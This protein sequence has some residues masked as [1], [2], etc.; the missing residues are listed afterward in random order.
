MHELSG[1]LLHQFRTDL[2]RAVG[3][4]NVRDDADELKAVAVDQYW[5]SVMWTA[6]EQEIAVPYF[7]V[8]PETTE[9]VSAVMSVCNEYKVPVVVR[10][11]GSGTQGGAVSF[12]PGIVLGMERMNKIID[13]DEKS[14]VLTAEP[15]INGEVLELALNERGLML[16]H[17]PSSFAIASLGGYLAAR[18]SGVMSTKYGKAEDLVLSIEVVLADGTIIETL[19][20]P[21][22]ANGPDLLQLFVGS[23]GTLGVITKIRMQLDPLPETRLFAVYEFPTVEDGIEASR[24]IMTERLRPAVIRLYDAGATK[25]SLQDTGHDLSGVNSII[26]VDG[27]SA[28]AEPTIARIREICEEVGGIARPDSEGEHW[29][30]H[31]YDFYR[32]PLQPGYPKMYGT[33]ETLT[34]FDKLPGLYQAKRDHVLSTYAQ[35]DVKYTAH[36]SHWYPWGGMIYD[37]FYIDNPPADAAEAL[38]L[39][40]EI[41]DSCSRINLEHTGMLNE[42]HGIGFKLGRLMREQQGATFDVLLGIKRQ[43]DPKGILNPGKLGFG[44]W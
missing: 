8:T 36:F 1:L 19:P 33:V 6:K 13:I 37:R 17:Y 18:G 26:M 40:N 2:I 10:G 31:R 25:R 35:Y 39:H 3:Q 12:L 16:A 24:R 9:Q 34:T 5:V 15:G 30:E 44:I 23:E 41:W 28:I 20:V 21:N 32:P 22:H 42:H 43:L 4:E 38:K 14:L 29:W 7:Y 11:L 27:Q